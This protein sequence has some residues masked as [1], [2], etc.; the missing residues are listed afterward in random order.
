MELHEFLNM[1]VMDVTRQGGRP[2]P[3]DLFGVELELEGKHVVAV[4]LENR[5][6]WVPHKDGSLRAN[7]G[8]C[9]EWV[10]GRPL[11]L[12]KA[13]SAVDDLFVGLDKAKA[14]IVTSNR[15]STHVHVNMSDK[16]AYQVVNLFLLFTVLE[17]ILDSY[18]GADRN[19]N[20]F[21][22]ST[23]LAE[24]NLDVFNRSCFEYYNFYE[25]SEDMRY[26]S[27][28]MSSLNKFGSVEFRGMRGLDNARDVKDWL[29]ILNELTQFACYKMGNP[30]EDLILGVSV[31]TPIGFLREVFSQKCLDALIKD[32]TGDE[33]N[34]SIF[35]G[36]RLIQMTASKFYQ[37]WD[38]VIKREPDFWAKVA[39]N[40]KKP[41]R[42]VDERERD[43]DEE[44]DEDGDVEEMEDVLVEEAVRVPVVGAGGWAQRHLENDM[45]MRMN[46]P[47]RDVPA[48]ARAPEAAP[49][50][51]L[52]DIYFGEPDRA[53]PN[54]P[55]PGRGERRHG[56]E[57]NA[58][59]YR[60]AWNE[61]HGRWVKI[62]PAR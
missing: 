24:Y 59:G 38:K 5:G 47:L 1:N 21:C 37:D 9:I 8:D 27:L 36:L 12:D 4:P 53:Y 11:G 41:H 25:F 60:Y 31:K 56:G 13:K 58:G 19:G 17:D 61:E 22:L 23:R 51:P 35:E 48:F 29:D 39:P 46:R 16:S 3:G 40:H 54:D 2:M 52:G 57:L 49:E 44:D 7:H 30:F 45:N 33:I 34:A 6:D 55:V 15:T 42:L 43:E 10:F 20:L 28:N 50:V 14:K 32:R 26:S 18:C 62:G